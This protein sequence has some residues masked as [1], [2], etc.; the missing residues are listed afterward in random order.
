MT[1]SLNTGAASLSDERPTYI[2]L[3]SGDV[4]RATDERYSV[5]YHRWKPIAS[6]YVG[7]TVDASTRPV[8]RTAIAAGGAQEHNLRADMTDAESIARNQTHH[9]A[10]RF[11]LAAASAQTEIEHD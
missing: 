2:F 5:T 6:L 4:I 3:A 9:E 10:M 11:V 7:T 1:T 8:R